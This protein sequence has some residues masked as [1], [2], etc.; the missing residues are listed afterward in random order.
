[1]RPRDDDLLSLFVD[2]LRP[3][4]TA[5]ALAVFALRFKCDVLPARVERL[6]GARFRLTV[7]PPL[8]LPRSGEPHADTAAL[9]ERKGLPHLSGSRPCDRRF[10]VERKTKE[11]QY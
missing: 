11:R 6:A 4:M 7:F 10:H 1:M 2:A 5:P 3:A 8:P 9:M